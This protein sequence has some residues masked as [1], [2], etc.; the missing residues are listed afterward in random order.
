MGMLFGIVFTVEA[1]LIGLV[2]VGLAHIHRPLLIPIAVIAIVGVHFVPLA[3]VFRIPTYAV[4]GLVLVALAAGSLLIQDEAT[5][6]LALSIGSAIA[7][8]ASA[9]TVLAVHASA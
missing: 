7:L 1:G 9:T 3:K 8:W 4:L 2:S 5:R 6:V